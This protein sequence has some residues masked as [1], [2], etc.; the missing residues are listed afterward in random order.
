MSGL[1]V[2]VGR[3]DEKLYPVDGAHSYIHDDNWREAV[4]YPKDTDV[5]N[6]MCGFC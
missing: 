1:P 2:R 5:G 6:E 3:W 4:L